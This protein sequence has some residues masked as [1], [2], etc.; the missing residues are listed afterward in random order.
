MKRLFLSFGVF[1]MIFGLV[2]GTISGGFSLFLSRNDATFDRD[3]AV[4]QLTSDVGIPQKW[5]DKYDVTARN[6]IDLKIDQDGDGLTLIDEYTY[7]TDPRN[8]D[9]DGDGYFDGKEVR[10]GYSPSGDGLMDQNDNQVPDVWEIEKLGAIVQN[11]EDDT[12]HDDLPLI[13][14]YVYGTDPTRP[15][16]DGDGYADGQEVN[17]GYDPDAPGETRIK[18]TLVIN[19][20][21]VETPV[22]LSKSTEESSIQKDLERGV[23]HYPGTPLPGQRG[24]SY[25][26][27]HS[28]NYAWAQGS[29]N[30]VFKNLNELVVGD[31]MT[32]TQ[33]LNNGKEIT[34]TFVVSLK[35]EVAPD[36]P[37]IFADTKTQELTLTTCWPL[38]TNV[39]RLMVKAQLRDI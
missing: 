19:K 8:P 25:I 30:Y 7:N 1:I 31:V 16:T 4:E 36:D 33:R 38:G 27:G 5:L 20:I 13:D 18:M 29:Y 15:D 12:D 35:E 22:V 34:N 2:Y 23:V 10:D 28:S 37:R 14:E 24:N 39:R 9:T 26:A 11:D 32:V 3:V 6:D 17:G 21:S